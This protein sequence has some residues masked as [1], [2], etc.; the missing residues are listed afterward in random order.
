MA[1]SDERSFE[2]LLESAQAPFEGWDFVYIENTG[3]LVDGLLPWSYGSIVLAAFGCADSLL[4]MGTGGGETLSY[5][6]PL[7][8]HTWATECYPPNVPVARRRLEPLGVTVLQLENQDHLPFEDG[9]LDLVISRHESFRAEEIYRVLRQGGLFITQ[10]VGNRN[11]L[12]IN[13]LLGK[14]AERTPDA[15]DL[16]TD[17]AAL[18]AAGFQVERQQEA[19]PRMRVF[20]VGALVYMLRAIPWISPGFSVENDRQVLYDLHRRIRAE[21]FVEATNHRYLIVARSAR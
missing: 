17:V 13:A 12:E 20:D 15:S 11:D 18:T 21:G 1:C 7:P 5:L 19:F 4:D 9:Q 6:A 8:S 2:R 16:T 14:H 3:R 10:Q